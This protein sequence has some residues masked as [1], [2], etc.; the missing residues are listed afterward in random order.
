MWRNNA[1]CYSLKASNT[2]L[3]RPQ[4]ASEQATVPRRLLNSL[5]KFIRRTICVD[6]AENVTKKRDTRR[7]SCR[8]S[9][10]SRLDRKTNTTHD[11]LGGNVTVK[12]RLTQGKTR[13]SSYHAKVSWKFD[14]TQP[15]RNYCCQKQDRE[16]F[17]EAMTMKRP[18][19]NVRESVRKT[20][21]KSH[22][23]RCLINVD[24]R[25]S[26]RDFPQTSSD[27]CDAKEIEVTPINICWRNAELFEVRTK[28]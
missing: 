8:V 14:P 11:N 7:I 9:R 28:Q 12:R 4:C 25:H 1:R 27:V 13:A 15:H 6:S 22:V 18:F 19:K 23:G 10:T 17:N 20:R 2:L 5:S 26:P 3:R 24:W 16:S 21:H